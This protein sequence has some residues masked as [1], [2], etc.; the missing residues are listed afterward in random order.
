MISRKPLLK[1]KLLRERKYYVLEFYIEQISLALKCT[2]FGDLC[3]RTKK[4]N[5]S[6]QTL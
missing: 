5:V 2:E 6:M 4:I 1:M 3:C